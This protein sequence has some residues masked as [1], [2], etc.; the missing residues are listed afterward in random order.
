MYFKC[1]ACCRVTNSITTFNITI[2]D[3]NLS[4]HMVNFPKQHQKY[5]YTERQRT[6]GKCVRFTRLFLIAANR[7]DGNHLKLRETVN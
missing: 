7:H 4:N 3:F 2:D 1:T 6:A 5:C